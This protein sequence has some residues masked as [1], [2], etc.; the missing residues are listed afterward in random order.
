MLSAGGVLRVDENSLVVHRVRV[1]ADWSR[2]DVVFLAANFRV[3]LQVQV[4]VGCVMVAIIGG[5]I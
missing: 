4:V 1:L 2:L 5:S 3:H